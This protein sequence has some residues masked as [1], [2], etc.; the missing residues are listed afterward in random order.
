MKPAPRSR[1]RR[2]SCRAGRP[3]RRRL[4]APER[5]FRA[6]RRGRR[7][8]RGGYRQRVAPRRAERVHGTRF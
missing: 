4:A 5:T 1:V 8:R 3:G 2:V 7:E 6:G